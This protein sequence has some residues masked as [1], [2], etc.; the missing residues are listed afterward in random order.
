MRGVMRFGLRALWSELGGAVGIDYW[1]SSL[2]T[3]DKRSNVE[4]VFSMIK[5]K[6]GERIRS[7]TRT[8]QVN[9]VL[10]KVLAH[11]LCCVIQSVY[12][13]GI[14]VDFYAD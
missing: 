13:L 6:F 4:T 8:A 10:C 12:E 2:R 5:A 11:N 9:E 7:K 1:P 3:S 14:E